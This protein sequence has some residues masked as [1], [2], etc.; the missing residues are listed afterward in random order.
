MTKNGSILDQGYLLH[1]VFCHI[2]AK[3]PSSPNSIIAVERW[4]NLTRTGWF[5][6]PKSRWTLN[7]VTPS[8]ENTSMKQTPAGMVLPSAPWGPTY[9]VETRSKWPVY[10]RNDTMRLA[11]ALELPKCKYDYNPASSISAPNR[12]LQFWG[13]KRLSVCNPAHS[14]CPLR[15][16]LLRAR[17]ST[18]VIEPRYLVRRSQY[19]LLSIPGG[20]LQVL[21][22][23][24]LVLKP[25]C[26]LVFPH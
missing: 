2:N 19:I 8:V 10:I 12:R 15:R 4:L 22:M 16:R 7:A 3:N 13:I 26:L 14:A 9:P 25:L 5:R 24:G 23:M 20:I 6:N 17:S 11:S 21:R 1:V 18:L